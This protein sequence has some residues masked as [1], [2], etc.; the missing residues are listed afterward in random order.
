[1]IKV[2]EFQRANMLTAK[3]LLVKVGVDPKYARTKGGD[4]DHG[5]F[6]A[7]DRGTCSPSSLTIEITGQRQQGG[8]FLDLIENIRRAG[9]HAHG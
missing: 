6:S 2:Q 9:N 5:T 1:V 7:R 4:A 3:L 8:K